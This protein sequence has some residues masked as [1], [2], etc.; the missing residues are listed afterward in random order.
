M[1]LRAQAP[2]GT[3]IFIARKGLIAY[4]NT[5]AGYVEGDD[6]TLIGSRSGSNAVAVWMILMTNGPYGWQEK[7]LFYK[8]ELRG[9]VSSLLT[10]T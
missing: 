10:E 5:A 6:F 9:C 3:G 4:T 7:S 8:N 1:Y 2:Y